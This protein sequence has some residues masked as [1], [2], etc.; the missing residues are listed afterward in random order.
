MLEA[1]KARALIDS[2]VS[3]RSPKFR[4][5]YEAREETDENELLVFLKPEITGLG[6]TFESALALV[7]SCLSEFG[8]TI[9]ACAA[10][11][12]EY[13]NSYQLIAAHYGTIN[14]VSRLG[15]EAFGSEA[16]DSMTSLEKRI[17]QLP[18]VLGAH[19]F[20]GRFRYFTPRALAVLYDNLDS[21]RLSGGTHGVVVNIEGSPT[22]LLNGF[23]PAQLDHFEASGKSI[24]CM[25]A[26]SK[27]DWGTLRGTMTGATDPTRAAEGSIRQRLLV[28]RDALGLREVTSLANG[29]HVSAG[30]VEAAIEI[31]RY[32]SD[33]ESGRTIEF[34]DTTAG[35]VLRSVVGP[36][37]LPALVADEEV[38][39]LDGIRSGFDA[40]EETN[41]SELADLAATFSVPAPS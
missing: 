21:Q 6:D 23:H 16:R 31:A 7:S 2:A 13:L 25:V 24:L 30:P 29:V 41:L 9:G 12:A 14:R 10:L 40:T 18:T 20:L 15:T 3:S 37:V 38:A 4:G 35:R 26:Y 1:D 19:Q 32:L 39:T 34:A 28:Q 8:V 5:T 17:G 11:P 36:D 27:T 22:V 33:F